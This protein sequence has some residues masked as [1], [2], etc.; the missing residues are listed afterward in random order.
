MGM[1][2]RR[3]WRQ[4]VGGVLA[5]YGV[6]NWNGKSPGV[7][8]IWQVSRLFM[9]NGSLANAAVAC[10]LCCAVLCLSHTSTAWPQHLPHLI[11]AFKV[12]CVGGT[13]TQRQHT[14]LLFVACAVLFMAL[15]VRTLMLLHAKLW[16]C[17]LRTHLCFCN[18]TTHLPG[19]QA[20]LSHLHLVGKS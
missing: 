9:T 15:S 2:Q 20:R 10:C 3:L 14:Q 11:N 18:Q 8:I 7:L 13:W 17:R 19:T 1:Q 12:G 16:C 6:C 4:Y 5:L